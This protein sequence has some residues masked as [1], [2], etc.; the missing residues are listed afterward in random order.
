MSRE[1]SPFSGLN[2]NL[3]PVDC[4]LASTVFCPLVGGER[5]GDACL[6][7]CFFG[8]VSSI[9]QRLK[10]VCHAPNAIDKTRSSMAA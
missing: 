5:D 2:D 3:V 7:C 9:G 10:V 1:D 8:G 4:Y 6:E